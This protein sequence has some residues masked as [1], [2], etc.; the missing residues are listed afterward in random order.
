[1]Y[2]FNH[3]SV[4]IR[5]TKEQRKAERNFDRNYFMKRSLKHQKNRCFFC[6]APITMSDHLDHLLP[7]YRGGKSIV[8]NLFAT[9]KACNLT[10]SAEQLVITNESTILFFLNLKNEF[11]KWVGQKRK[12][13]S[14]KPN[15]YVYMYWNY[16]ADLFTKVKHTD[17][18]KLRNYVSKRGTT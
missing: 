14:Y 4:S 8:Y 5:T 2:Y 7:V 12:H 3:S 10:K 15:S 17:R 11:S 9:C 6:A 1:M 13:G 18:I 16:R